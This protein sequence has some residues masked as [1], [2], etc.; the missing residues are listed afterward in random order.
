MTGKHFGLG[1]AKPRPKAVG[2]GFRLRDAKKTLFQSQSVF[3][4]K[5]TFFYN[6]TFFFKK[7]QLKKTPPK[8]FFLTK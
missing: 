6:K 7:K 1:L 5:K 8:N 2:I 4:L 3:F